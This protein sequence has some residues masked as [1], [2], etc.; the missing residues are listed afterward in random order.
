MAK[1]LCKTRIGVDQKGLQKVWFCAHPDDY[2]AFLEKTAGQILSVV[3]CSFWYDGEPE[4]PYDKK[5]LKD[6]LSLMQ[7]FVLPV[8]ERFLKEDNRAILEELQ[9][10]FLN[11]IPILPLLEDEA[12][13]NLFN[14]K[15]GN[16]QYLC[17][18]KKDDTTVPYEEK[19]K[20]FLLD[21]LIGDELA[22]KARDAFDAYIFLSYRKKDRKYA[23]ELMRLIHQNDFC[24][25]VAIWYDEF[26]IPGE[27]FDD[28]IFKALQKS[29]LFAMVVTPNL[30]EEN[31]YVLQKEY[32]AA[33]A[34]GIDI[35]PA[36]MVQTDNSQ[37]REKFPEIPEFSDARNKKSLKTALKNSLSAIAK[38]EQNANP[39]HKFFIGLAYLNGIDVEIDKKR[40]LRLIKESSDDGLIEGTK[41]LI[42]MYR[43]GEGVERNKE[44]E[45]FYQ[46][47]FSEQT[48]TAHEKNPTKE[49]FQAY[50]SALDR[51]AYSHEEEYLLETAEKNYLALLTFC[52]NT[53]EPYDGER[54]FWYTGALRR[55]ASCCNKRGE[56]KK[57]EKYLSESLKRLKESIKRT[58][59]LSLELEMITNSLEL[60][61]TQY[62]QGRTTL[63]YHTVKEAEKLLTKTEEKIGTDVQA[64][65]IPH[66]Y[67]FMS[68]LCLSI[69]K[70][71]DALIYAQKNIQWNARLSPL[72]HPVQTLY[73]DFSSHNL[74]AE[75]LFS[76]Q[77]KAEAESYAKK[78]YSFAEEYYQAT[79]SISA[80]ECL[81]K[82]LADMGKFA[83]I[84]KDYTK[85]K[86]LYLDAYERFSVL[87]ER[88]FSSFS[89]SWQGTLLGSFSFLAKETGDKEASKRYKK[90][91]IEHYESALKR[92]DNLN[93]R[94]NLAFAYSVYA[95][96]FT[97]KN[98][99]AE[100]IRY[101]EKSAIEYERVY[102]QTYDFRCISAAAQRYKTVG[103]IY[104]QNKSLSLPH[105]IYFYQKAMD[106]FSTVRTPVDYE[107]RQLIDSARF[108][109]GNV[110]EK[111]SFL[112][113]LLLYANCKELA[114]TNPNDEKLKALQK[115]ARKNLYDYH[116]KFS[117][118]ERLSF[119][120]YDNALDYFTD[121]QN[122]TSTRIAANLLLYLGDRQTG[123]DARFN[124]LAAKRH[125]TQLLKYCPNEELVSIQKE[126]D[127]KITLTYTQDEE[128]QDAIDYESIV[129]SV[130]AEVEE[131]EEE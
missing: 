109:S 67:S 126:L 5:A 63:V 2:P 131:N 50:V 70:F 3:N 76:L 53:Q 114:K 25:D 105:S 39:S 43:Y 92:M 62:K 112:C 28:A 75:I 118:D 24:R 84:Q 127:E 13:A 45:F 57:A 66:V 68:T 35:L 83:V 59:D 7:L 49:T 99:Q 91:Q 60:A 54:D 55:L 116:E 95:G 129:L 111:E 20:K 98:E 74:I 117:G 100:K 36:E 33:K 108:L 29:S 41:K 77:R 121:R 69:K 90:Q 40:A 64:E 101:Y 38:K 9:I 81:A 128:E 89:V 107:R 27:N 12:L 23:N 106:G 71:E 104:R 82:G 42:Q 16:L 15:C 51:L 73:L 94:S 87:A 37:L 31:N 48:K 85:A 110:P 102:K 11:R 26:L 6:D 79:G 58:P 34:S 86:R 124:Y 93:W 125:F 61:N 47:R 52:E 96:M 103:D 78:A 80:Q 1:L 4:K 44:Q 122:E 18:T 56:H 14:E 113:N 46:T 123:E 19:L 97:K 119:S 88:T 65:K 8:T 72:R 115:S 22:Q 120:V 30:L 130:F 21:V 10:A 17:P 32:P